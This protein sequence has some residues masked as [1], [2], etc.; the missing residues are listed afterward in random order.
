M[1]KRGRKKGVPHGLPPDE[2]R[3]HA[4]ARRYKDEYR[5]CGRWAL[6]GKKVCHIHGGRAGAPKGNKNPL[7]N[8]INERITV[9]TMNEEEK[10]IYNKILKDSGC[11]DLDC[12]NKKRVIIEK[13]AINYIRQRRMLNSLDVIAEKDELSDKDKDREISLH[14]AL[15]Q[16]QSVDIRAIDLMHKIENTITLDNQS[17]QII[18]TDNIDDDRI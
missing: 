10:Q 13:W 11:T 4:K 5:R 2:K 3:C 7:K 16:V 17:P 1:A 15:N 8:H 18:H 12:F 14:N 9:E 6:K